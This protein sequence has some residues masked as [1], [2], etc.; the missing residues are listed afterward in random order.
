MIEKLQLKNYKAHSSLR[1]EIDER[2]SVIAGRNGAGKTSLLKAF[3]D[4]AV[5]YT[6][7]VTTS[8]WQGFLEGAD[9][10][11]ETRDVNGSSLRFV[12]NYPVEIE[13]CGRLGQIFGWNISKTE[14]MASVSSSWNNPTVIDSP[15]QSLVPKGQIDSE[16]AS[17]TTLPLI[18][19]YPAD[20]SWNHAGTNAIQALSQKITRKDAFQTFTNASSQVQALIHWITAR[21]L[22]RLQ[23]A[24]ETGV[25]FKDV[26]DDELAWASA[27][28]HT[29][30]PEF[31]S[32]R[33][34]MKRQAVVVEWSNTAQADTAAPVL[35]EH[36]SDGQRT[37]MS[38][39]LDI[40]RRML[41]LNG[42]L[43]EKT[44]QDTP[45]LILIDELETHLHPRWQR[46]ITRGLAQAFPSAQFVASTHSPQVLSELR[47]EQILLLHPGSD[48]TRHPQRSWGLTSNEVLE[49]VMEGEPRNTDIS[50]QLA[51]I[52]RAIED[53][54]YDAAQA[55]L[56]SLRQDVGDIPDVLRLDETLAW[57]RDGL[58]S[59][60]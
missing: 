19:F 13:A 18:I 2:F 23:T 12:K 6:P 45:G 35:F 39:V 1:V 3:L 46:E 34:D 36:L 28:I 9:I 30:L 55:L 29:V 7:F 17:K 42:H 26:K 41:I 4:A 16:Q 32:L 51:A 33:Y 50:G 53:E 25:S 22:E 54:N 60:Q 49:E 37:V 20:R 21:S 24:T 38:L 47:A 31:E 44:L 5:A 58:E 57:Y 10:P 15:F 48:S 14:S 27:A 52:E 43:R 40:A 56:N 8:P 11:Y 59:G